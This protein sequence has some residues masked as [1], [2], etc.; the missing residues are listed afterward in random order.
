MTYNKTRRSSKKSQKN[1]DV[2]TSTSTSKFPKFLLVI[3]IVIL[4]LIGIILFFSVGKK[5]NNIMHS[6][7]GYNF[8]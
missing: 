4:T 8:Y 1:Y 2:S 5:H 3:I 6:S 7:F